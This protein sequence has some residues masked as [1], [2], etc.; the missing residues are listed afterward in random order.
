VSFRKLVLRLVIAAAAGLVLG[1]A[2]TPYEQFDDAG[3][4]DLSERARAQREELFSGAEIVEDFSDENFVSRLQISEEARYEVSGGVIDFDRSTAER[5]L[6]L[7]PGSRYDS[8]AVLVRV[9]F[10]TALSVHTA[11]APEFDTDVEPRISV[12]IDSA[13]GEVRYQLG[14]DVIVVGTLEQTFLREWV[15]LE[16]RQ[17]NRRI[18]LYVNG[19]RLGAAPFY[20]RYLTGVSVYNFGAGRGAVDYIILK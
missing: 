12:G 16:M 4:A 2:T 6:S 8:V 5:V 14:N 11:V 20:D 1:C 18:A 13:R 19:S 9:D 15:L 17:E 7:Y 3:A 10:S